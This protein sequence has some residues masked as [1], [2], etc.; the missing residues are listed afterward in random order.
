MRAVRPV[1]YAIKVS[2]LGV[3]PLP[4]KRGRAFRYNLLLKKQKDF[5]YN[6]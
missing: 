6:P 5:R 4:K 1:A 3:S 2:Y